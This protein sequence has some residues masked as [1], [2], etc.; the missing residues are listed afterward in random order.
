MRSKVDSIGIFT[1]HYNVLWIQHLSNQNITFVNGTEI[2][3][4]MSVQKRAYPGNGTLFLNQW[5]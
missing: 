5:N 4:L 1:F 3:V 2:F